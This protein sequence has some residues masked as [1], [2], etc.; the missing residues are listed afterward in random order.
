MAAFEMFAQS[1]PENLTL[2]IDTYETEAGA[3]KV[4]ALAPRLAA[5][6][7]KIGAVRLDSGNLTALSKSVRR[8]LNAVVD[9]DTVFEMGRKFGG[10]VITALARVDGWPASARPSC[11]TR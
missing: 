4:V 1:R 5:R 8:I 10:S 3:R 2:L 6:G 11:N 7:I 9:R